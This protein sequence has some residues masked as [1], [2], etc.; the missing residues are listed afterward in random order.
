MTLNYDGHLHIFAPY[1]GNHMW[2]I[3]LFYTILCQKGF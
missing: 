1:G 2:V 3:T